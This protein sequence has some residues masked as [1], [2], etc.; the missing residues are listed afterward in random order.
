MKRKLAENIVVR[1]LICLFIFLSALMG[2]TTY[3]QGQTETCIGFDSIKAASIEEYIERIAT[4]LIQSQSIVGMG[5]SLVHCGKIIHLSGHGYADLDNQ[6]SVD[7]SLHLFRVGSVTKAFTFTALMQLVEAG[8]VKIDANIN[9]YLG[10]FQ[11]PDGRFGPIKVKDLFT[12][13]TGFED[14]A[15]GYLFER[16]PKDQISLEAFLKRHQPSRVRQAGSVTSYSNY[17]VGLAGRIIE[18]VSGKSYDD[19]ITNHIFA[20]LEMKSSTALEPNSLIGGGMSPELA[21]RLAS[22]YSVD[23]QGPELQSFEYIGHVS[24]A[25]AISSTPNDMARFMLA[26][27]SS[28]HPG[29]FQML[30]PV[31]LDQFRTR[32]YSN[33]I[34]ATD[35]AFGLLNGELEGYET[36]HHRGATLTSFSSMILV[37]D[38]QVGVFIT[39]NGARN[40]LAP[41]DLAERI[42]TENFLTSGVNERPSLP[43]QDVSSYT[44]N[45]LTNRRSF[46]KLEKIFY[47]FA[48]LAKVKAGEN[49]KL[50]I[51]GPKV[52]QG[53]YRFLG[54][55]KFENTQSGKVIMFESDTSG[56]MHR[57]YS[58]EGHIAYERQSLS[59]SLSLLFSIFALALVA[60]LTQLVASLMEFRSKV[61]SSTV[62]TALGILSPLSV[63]L[64]VVLFV[65][66]LHQLAQ[67]GTEIVYI[68]PTSFLKILV[69]AILISIPL[70]AAQTGRI[71]FY[72]V[73]RDLAGKENVIQVSFAFFLVLLI[74]ILNEWNMIGFKW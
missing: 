46:T 50:L 5:V 21:A 2:H 53:T 10:D 74:L 17:S 45:Y 55:R 26:I 28:E 35:F 18:I 6:I 70:W 68:W 39:T 40:P 72:L 31:T 57:F 15:A 3:A 41:H 25:G 49:N 63:I 13:R 30:K 52:D 33:R 65:L 62:W 59:S 16:D 24:P 8:Q 37:P 23:K 66:S 69:I 36:L 12:H 47:P 20:P 29:K 32:P 9:D 61:T 42:L 38:K 44:G 73:K 7:P 4:P 1:H 71:L 54:D 34:G 51:S 11:I 27:V 48:G 43:L 58:T 14:G 22:V 56:S 19:Y 60:A 67:F 64:V